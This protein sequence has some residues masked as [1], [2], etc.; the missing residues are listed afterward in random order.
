MTHAES[1]TR[2]IDRQ[3]RVLR[4]LQHGLKPASG[5]R[6]R[7][8]EW[9]AR[10]ILLHLLGA[11]GRTFED[12]QASR[13]HEPSGVRQRGGEYVERP[14]LV[15]ATEVAEALA[16]S[17]DQIRAELRDMDDNALERPVTIGGE[18]SNVVPIGLVVRHGL[19][20]HFDEHLAQL[21][22]VMGDRSED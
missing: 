19:T 7:E 2:H 22:G 6:Q 5:P 12:L 16:R 1:I 10:E 4:S 9:D 15:T 8:T 20:D 3:E 14:E 17:L 21:R 13:G 18:E 11:V